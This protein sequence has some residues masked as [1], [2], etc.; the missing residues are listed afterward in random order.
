VPSARPSGESGA[1][2]AQTVE[3]VKSETAGGRSVAAPKVR[4]EECLEKV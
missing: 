4:L 3:L 2:L 1:K